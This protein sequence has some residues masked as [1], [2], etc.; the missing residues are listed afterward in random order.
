MVGRSG[1][2]LLWSLTVVAG[3]P[4]GPAVCSWP[5]AGPVPARCAGPAQPW[6]LRPQRGVRGLVPLK[7]HISCRP[8]AKKTITALTLP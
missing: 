5:P 1:Q 8:Q 4:A 3:V 6:P 7:S 2:C